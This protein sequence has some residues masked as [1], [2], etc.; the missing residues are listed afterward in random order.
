MKKNRVL[1]N[2]Q[3]YNEQCNLLNK[4]E[5]YRI[6][7]SVT[8]DAFHFGIAMTLAFS[9]LKIRDENLKK[10]H[11][12]LTHFHKKLTLSFFLFA[13]DG[14]FH[15]NIFA[16]LFASDVENIFAWTIR[17]RVDKASLKIFLSSTIFQLLKTEDFFIKN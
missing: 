17:C 3:D 5:F 16:V 1:F 15:R 12:L 9:G 6:V 10:A 13:I 2:G 11:N 14:N 4:N 7:I 8:F